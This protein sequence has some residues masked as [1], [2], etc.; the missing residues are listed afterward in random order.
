MKGLTPIIGI[1]LL[2][3]IA[4]III[5]SGFVFFQDSINEAKQK[6]E[7][8]LTKQTRTEFT[9]LR[10]DGAS[11][12]SVIVRNT[13]YQNILKDELLVK[14]DGKVVD[15]ISDFEILK[16]DEFKS[17]VLTEPISSGTHV[18]SVH[19]I[20]NFDSVT[21]T[22]RDTSIDTP[23]ATQL[24]LSGKNNDGGTATPCTAGYYCDGN[25]RRYRYSNCNTVDASG[26]SSNKVCVSG[27]CYT[28]TPTPIPVNG[29]CGNT[30]NSCTYGTFFD[31][32]DSS[33]NYLWK[34]LG[35]YGG[36]TTN[37]SLVKPYW[38][39]S[40]GECLKYDCCSG[41]QYKNC[42]CVGVGNCNTPEPS[43]YSQCYTK[44]CCNCRR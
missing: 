16:P 20:G 2:L 10:I 9:S 18:V 14:V 19:S 11:R 29:V 40:W 7:L 17:F 23:T 27:N 32:E 38:S 8:G 25:D 3:M 5:G 24:S 28:P 41:R 36:Q 30:L 37:C 34:C 33:T 12:T 21:I 13:G 39:C 1:I 43:G 15:A 22:D 26:C 44:G 42:V 4:V 6:T 35:I 31:V